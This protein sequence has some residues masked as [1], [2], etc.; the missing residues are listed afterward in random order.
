MLSMKSK[1]TRSRAIR[2]KCLDCVC[3]QVSEVKEC[4]SKACPL[5]PYRMGGTP[6]DTELEETQ[7][8]IAKEWDVDEPN[9]ETWYKKT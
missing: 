7:K 8:L 5:W 6:T 2:A 1:M 9:S 4:P 3:D